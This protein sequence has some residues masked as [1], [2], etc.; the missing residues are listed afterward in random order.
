MSDS[1]AAAQPTVG[2]IGAG[3]MATA[4]F[5]GMIAKKVVSADRVIAS[6]TFAPL[7]AKHEAALK[8]RTTQSTA[9]V[10]AFADVVFIAVKPAGVPAV[11]AELAPALD[12]ARHLV[13]SVCAGVTCASLAAGLPAGA[14]VVRVMPNTPSL[15]GAGAAAF[16][17]GAHA[18]RADLALVLRLLSAVGLAVEV[19]EKDLDAV[20]GLSASG[21]AFVFQFIEALADGG[22][23]A[24]LPRATASALAVQT[25]LGSALMVQ[26]TGAHPA[27]LK[28]QVASPGGTT[29]AGVHALERGGL[30][31]AVIGAVV[32]ATERAEEMGR[33][34]AKL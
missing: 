34:V 6:D 29:I 12:V 11:L 20:T 26:R 28:D 16:A 1:S 18:S 32:A 24:G 9:A 4:L 33:P 3:N 10:A 25:V 7:L 19:G 5:E 27:V 23:R 2:F 30:R 22:V 15:V 31:A 13:V 8:I 14:R 17:P 21:P